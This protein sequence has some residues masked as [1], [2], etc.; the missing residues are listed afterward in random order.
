MLKSFLLNQEQKRLEKSRRK[1][2][3]QRKRELR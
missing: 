2:E 1:E 3:R